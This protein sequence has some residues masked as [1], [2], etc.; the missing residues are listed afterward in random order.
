MKKVKLIIAAA[1]IGTMVTANLLPGVAY[2]DDINS[3]VIANEVMEQVKAGEVTL[4]EA[5]ENSISYYRNVKMNLDSFWE[6]VALSGVGEDINSEL[7]NLPDWDASVVSE[8]TSIIADTGYILGI[9]ARGEDPKNFKGKDFAKILAEKQRKYGNGL[10]SF[11]GSNFNIWAIIALE[12][13][14]Q[15][16]DKEFALETLL[17][18]QFADGSYGFSANSSW[19]GSTDLTGMALISLGL[20]QKDTA[21]KNDTRIQESIDKALGY[22]ESKKL[23]DG[24]FTGYSSNADGNSTSMAITGIVSVG[25]D[26]TSERWSGVDTGILGMQVTAE[27]EAAGKGTK[28]QFYWQGTMAND[29][30][31]YQCLVALGEIKS[32][33]SNWD[34]LD[35]QYEVY[36]EER[37]NLKLPKITASNISVNLGDPIDLL[38]GV[39]AEDMN[40]AD[41]TSKI[42]VKETNIPMVGNVVTGAGSYIA[43]YEVTDEEGRSNIKTIEVTVNQVENLTIVDSVD[44]VEAAIGEIEALL[45]EVD[46]DGKALY[47]LEEKEAVNLGDTH[48]V[49]TYVIKTNVERGIKKEVRFILPKDAEKPVITVPEVKPEPT[50]EPK[51]EEK[52]NTKPETKP[53]TTKPT[54]KPTLP[55]TG[56]QST[57][58]MAVAGVT[59]LLAGIGIKFRRK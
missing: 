51:P 17:K 6:I 9:I 2:A 30:A 38:T 36:E 50:P 33:E 19:G 58:P 52:P 22:L 21:F 47:A 1:L 44:K 53:D 8:D 34:R 12:I 4:D 3:E 29:M 35:R 55:Q 15:E 5:I 10:E 20:L 32:G 39:T 13:A 28:G 56:G 31:T 43:T 42:I 46:K 54:T 37:E 7:Y 25:E 16:Y 48:I 14:N 45:K 11:N 24:T 26:L 27:D 23:D 49:Y 57:L 18:Y 41:I 59:T 40:G